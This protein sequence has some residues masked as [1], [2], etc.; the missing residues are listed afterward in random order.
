MTS[1]PVWTEDALRKK[2]DALAFHAAHGNDAHDFHLQLGALSPAELR[3]ASFVGA[4]ALNELYH[5]EIVFTASLLE[6]ARVQEMLGHDARLHLPI[7]N[8]ARLVLGIAAAI[9]LIEPRDDSFVYRVTVVPRLWTLGL[10]KRSRVYQNMTTAQIV[11]EVLQRHGIPHVLSISGTYEPREYCLQYD[12]TDLELVQRLLADEGFVFTF[13][14]WNEA[15][16]KHAGFGRATECMIISDEVWVYT[17]IARVP[18]SLH[19]RP[20]DGGSDDG[21]WGEEPIV[22]LTSRSAIASNMVTLRDFDFERAGPVMGTQNPT[23]LGTTPGPLVFNGAFTTAH[24]KPPVATPMDLEVYEHDH[25]ERS[26][27]QDKRRPATRLEQLRRESQVYHGRSYCR[28]LYPGKRF[29]VL[30]YALAQMPEIVVTRIVHSS[31]GAKGGKLRY[32][33]EF[34]A[35]RADVMFRPPA[36]KRRHIQAVES[37]TVVGPPGRDVET[38]LH[39]RVRIQFHWDREQKSDAHSSCWIRVSQAW[40]GPTYGFQFVPRIGSEVLVAFLGG[41]PDHPVIV[42]SLPN[43]ANPLPHLLPQ[44]ATRSAIRSF[45]MPATGGFNEIL[46]NDQAGGE[47]FALRAERDHDIVVLNDHRLDVGHDATTTIAGRRHAR[48]GADDD[49]TITGS[50]RRSV[51]G[52]AVDTIGGAKTEAVAGGASLSVG[53]N[54]VT[55]TGGVAEHTI[56]GSSRTVIGAAGAAEALTSVNGEYRVAASHLLELHSEETIRFVVGPTTIELT[57]KGITVRTEKIDIGVKDAFEMKA[58]T[59]TQGAKETFATQGKKVTTA[60]DGGSLVLDSDAWLDGANVYL[61]CKGI[62]PQAIKDDKDPKKGKVTFKVDP[63]PGMEGPFTMVIAT[64]TGK[65]VEM[66]TDGDHKVE[67]D[68]LEGEKFTLVAVKKGEMVLQQHGDGK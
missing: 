13:E 19:Y 7:P 45:S 41:D 40:S 4:E 46:F 58:K 10:A 9:E 56:G 61:N 2:R 51:L 17:P 8:G 64:P 48:I 47:L 67:L 52:V 14:H 49:Q 63:P 18:P 59:I 24:K 44:D 6:A 11:D 32:D 28:R 36:P 1:T 25:E 16:A 26:A 29:H 15:E 39:G 35:V 21:N 43:I 55:T 53:G 37:A 50:A 60:S 38:D 54:Y 20:E 31:H 23:P 42:G 33:N 30:D 3:V 66:Q 22:R 27:R 57:P 62:K 65:I 12:E 5:F 68:G 34:E